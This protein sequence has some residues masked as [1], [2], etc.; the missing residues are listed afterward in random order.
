MGFF[1]LCVVFFSFYL[2]KRKCQEKTFETKGAEV[3]AK[4][5]RVE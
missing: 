2:K 1:F 5:E 4:S 3:G